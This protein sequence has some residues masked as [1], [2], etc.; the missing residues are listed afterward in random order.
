MR[1]EKYENLFQFLASY[2]HQDF[3]VEFEEPE[4][5]V[6]Q[7]IDDT[8]TETRKAVVYELHKLLAETGDNEMEDAAFELGCYF[9][10]QR[11]RGISMR[12]W[13]EQVV[14]KIRQSTT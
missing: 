11:H 1:K 10:P 13:L 9:S 2:F 5:A 7:F 6:Q 4:D 8:N 14:D 3:S 12:A